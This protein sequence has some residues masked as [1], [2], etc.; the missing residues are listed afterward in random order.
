MYVVLRYIDKNES[1]IKR[2]FGLVHI[3]DTSVKSYER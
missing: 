3:S 2:F 1:V